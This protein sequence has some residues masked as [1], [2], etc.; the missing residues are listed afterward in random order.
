MRRLP[1]LLAIVLLSSGCASLPEPGTYRGQSPP[2]DDGW[3]ARAGEAKKDEP[4]KDDPEKKDAADKTDN[5]KPEEP[6]KTLF[7]WAIVPKP[8]GN[9]NGNGNGEPEAEPI[10]TD[11]P[12]FT[13]A[14]STVGLNRVQLEAGYTYFRDRSGGLTTVTQT[15]PEAL[16][17][18]GMFAEWF[19]FRLGQTYVH[20]RTTGFGQT[21]EHVSGLA[22][23]YVG[24]KLWLTEQEGELPEM[25]IVFQATLPTAGRN[26]TANRVL[27]G[28]NFLYGWDVVPDFLSAAGSFGANRAVDDDGHSFVVVHQSFT[29]GYTLTEQLG[30]YTE[31]FALYPTS[32]IAPGTTPEHYA[33]G[34]FTYKVTPDFQLDVRAGCGL[35]RAAADFFAGAGFAVR[36]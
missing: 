24:T 21:T 9:G 29:I 34:G 17:R 18:V 26:L 25:A 36:Y 7:E 12:D 5:G 33:N 4:K 15:Y 8:P 10:V 6:P 1:Q 22:D 20:S 31:W 35:N 19:E 2:A 13:E 16:L 14:S 27:P 23:L 32:A 30:A 11:R 3:K 28:F